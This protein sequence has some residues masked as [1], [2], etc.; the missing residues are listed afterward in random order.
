MDKEN[1]P[2]RHTEEYYLVTKK[3][4]NPSTC[5]NMDGPQGHCVKWNESGREKHYNLTHGIIKQN[6][7]KKPKSELTKS[8]EN[9][10][11]VCMLSLFSW[12]DSLRPHG[13]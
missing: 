10:V 6:K 7:T 2:H 1:V 9:S 11:H 4:E 5:D 12:P 13:L 3:E 8:Q